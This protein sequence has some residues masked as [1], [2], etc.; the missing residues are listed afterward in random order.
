MLPSEPPY[1][2]F[3]PRCLP[4]ALH[5]LAVGFVTHSQTSQGRSVHHQGCWGKKGNELLQ[6]TQTFYECNKSLTN[7]RGFLGRFKPFSLFIKTM[8]EYSFTIASFSCCIAFNFYILFAPVLTV[9][10]CKQLFNLF[11]TMSSYGNMH[12]L[13]AL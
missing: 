5:L 2:V 10:V 12:T 6:L 1:L 11:P 4:R 7:R 13:Q 9:L 8:V 3:H